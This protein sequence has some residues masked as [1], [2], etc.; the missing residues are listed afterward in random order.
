VPAPSTL[1]ARA[2][3]SSLLDSARDHP[4]SAVA[5]TAAPA[6]PEATAAPVTTAAV[7]VDNDTAVA[8]RPIDALEGVEEAAQKVCTTANCVLTMIS[9]CASVHGREREGVKG[10]GCDSI[11]LFC[12]GRPGSRFRMFTFT[13]MICAMG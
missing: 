7:K 3:T 13:R 10:E 5:A 12:V 4:A 6:A 9:Q 1:P 2:V 8:K 11:V